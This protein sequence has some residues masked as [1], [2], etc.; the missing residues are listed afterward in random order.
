[1]QLTFNDIFLFVTNFSYLFVAETELWV[2]YV[3]TPRNILSN[4]P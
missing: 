2:S 1:M 4:I 3:I